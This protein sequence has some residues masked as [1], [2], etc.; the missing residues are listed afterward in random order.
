MRIQFLLSWQVRGA[1]HLSASMTRVT[2]TM[3]AAGKGFGKIGDP[4]KHETTMVVKSQNGLENSPAE[5]R[6]GSKGQGRFTERGDQLSDEDCP[7]Q[8]FTVQ[9]V[10]GDS[11]TAAVRVAP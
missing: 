8:G 7:S 5:A 11:S 9:P 4:E 1:R 2:A 10:I 6:S 3:P